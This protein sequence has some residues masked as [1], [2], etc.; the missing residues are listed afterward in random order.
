PRQRWWESTHSG[1]PRTATPGSPSPTGDP[2][3]RIPETTITSAVAPEQAT[4]PPSAATTEIAT[5]TPDATLTAVELPPSTPE[6]ASIEFDPGGAGA[7]IEGTLR[8]G[9]TVR[10]VLCAF[11]GQIM[12][13]YV[14][15]EGAV[16]RIY[17]EAGTELKSQDDFDPFWRGELPSTQ[18]YFIEVIHSASAIGPWDRPLQISVLINPRGQA[19]QWVDYRDEDNGFELRFSDYFAVGTPPPDIPPMRGEPML[20]LRFT[21]SEYFQETNLGDV[22]FVV[23]KSEEAEILSNCTSPAYA[24]REQRDRDPPSLGL[25]LT[26]LP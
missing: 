12:R 5:D 1:R 15:P 24:D 8:V 18:D 19:I 16:L 2:G 10:Y 17:G 26:V 3:R 6:T 14:E 20:S 22:Y 9:D 4:V 21:G 7:T 23:G 13:V 25:R 11:A